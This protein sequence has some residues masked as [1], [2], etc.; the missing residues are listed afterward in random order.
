MKIHPHISMAWHETRQTVL[1][2]IPIR[3]IFTAAPTGVGGGTPMIRCEPKLVRG[4]ADS[5]WG[6]FRVGLPM[7]WGQHITD[8]YP[9]SGKGCSLVYYVRSVQVP[10]NL[11]QVV[12]FNRPAWVQFDDGLNDYAT[13]PPSSAPSTTGPPD[14]PDPAPPLPKE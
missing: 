3:A 4:T 8:P 2:K 11:R 9:V 14:P 10:T 5:A 1:K 13:W 12:Y 7:L 6:T